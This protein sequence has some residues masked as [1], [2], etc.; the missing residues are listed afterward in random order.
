MYG[1]GHVF[2]RIRNTRTD[3]RTHRHTH[4]HTYTRTN[5]HTHTHTHT[6]TYTR[7][8]KGMLRQR[9]ARP[10][11]TNPPSYKLHLYLSHCLPLVDVEMPNITPIDFSDDNNMSLETMM[12]DADKRTTPIQYIRN[13]T[14]ATS[15]KTWMTW[16]PLEEPP[17]SDLIYIRMLLVDYILISTQIITPL[18]IR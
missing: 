7:T 5:T 15:K 13:K 1:V 11:S 4:I 9:R 6:R 18:I 16:S 12:R 14:F 17:T 2:V 8:N 10:H 3:T